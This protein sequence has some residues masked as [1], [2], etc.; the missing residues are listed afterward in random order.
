MLKE[1]Q[2][3]EEFLPPHVAGIK[4]KEKIIDG[5]SWIVEEYDLNHPMHASLK[6]Y[7]K[8]TL[9]NKKEIFVAKKI[10]PGIYEIIDFNFEHKIDSISN[11]KTLDNYGMIN[12]KDGSYKSTK[13]LGTGFKDI[14]W[15]NLSSTYGVAD[16]I[17]QIKNKFVKAIKSKDNEYVISITEIK[18]DVQ[19]DEGGWRWHKWGEYIGK[20]DPKCEYIADEPSIESVFCFHIYKVQLKKDIEL[21]LETKKLKIK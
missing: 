1:L 2:F 10:E 18:K 3:K 8:D 4:I 6:E 9:D 19:P 7:F 11:H 14:D 20:Q 12:L 15:E 13:D 5:N 21:N 16:N 17:E